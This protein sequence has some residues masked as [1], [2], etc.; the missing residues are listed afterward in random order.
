MSMFAHEDPVHD[1]EDCYFCYSGCQHEF[2]KAPAK[3]LESA[4]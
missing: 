1:G 2:E 4:A 3:Y